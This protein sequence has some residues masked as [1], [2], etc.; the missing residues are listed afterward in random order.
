[1]NTVDLVHEYLHL[2]LMGLKY[3]SSVLDKITLYEGLLLDYK[4]SFATQSSNNKT[5]QAKIDKI[6]QTQ[7]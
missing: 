3:E 7:D 1:M 6:N 4:Q 2:F 5:E